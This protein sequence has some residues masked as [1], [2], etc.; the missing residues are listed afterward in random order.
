MG[1]KI[2]ITSYDGHAINDG[3][4]YSAYFLADSEPL[5]TFE[6]SIVQSEIAGDFPDY[7]KG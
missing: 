7:V 4:T 5:S 2:T 6:S 3:T 1:E